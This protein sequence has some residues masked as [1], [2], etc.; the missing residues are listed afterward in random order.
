MMVYIGAGK[1]FCKEPDN[2]Y[3]RPTVVYLF[4]KLLKN[5]KS[6]ELWAI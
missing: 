3:F 5:V 1:L 6:V 4:L 2:K